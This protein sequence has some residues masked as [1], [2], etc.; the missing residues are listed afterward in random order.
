MQDRYVGDVGDFGKYGLLRHLAGHFDDLPP[1]VLG[2]IWYK[3]PDESHN[4]DGGK[5]QYL[6]NHARNSHSFEVCDPD[7]YNSL[8]T[9]IARGDR[10]LRE[11]QRRAILPPTTR[12][13]ETP[14]T[15]NGSSG[16]RERIEH[17]TRWMA[18]ALQATEEC[19]IVFVDPDNGLQC[20]SVSPYAKLG[21]KYA[22]EEELLPILDRGQTLVA[23][24][25]TARQAPADTQIRARLRTFQDLRPVLCEKVLALRFRRGNSRAFLIIPSVARGPM[26]RQRVDAILAGPWGQHF[27][28]VTLSNG[29]ARLSC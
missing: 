14:L 1:L 15:F 23:Y 7:L 22:F 16:R 9:L 17:R 13:Y 4:N 8:G 21:P 26:L 27:D 18:S 29:D 25:H 6:E 28:L 12:F 24:H 11:V 3:I 10:S 5:I 2:V 19:D 20:R